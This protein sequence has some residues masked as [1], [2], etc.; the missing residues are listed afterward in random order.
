MRAFAS[1]L[2]FV[3]NSCGEAV[4]SPS[5]INVAWRLCRSFAELCPLPLKIP[6]LL[7]SRRVF[8]SLTSPPKPLRPLFPSAA[9]SPTS[10]SSSA[11]RLSV[12]RFLP[13]A[14]CTIPGR[15]A[16]CQYW[17]SCVSSFSSFG[18]LSRKLQK[19]GMRLNA[20]VHVALFRH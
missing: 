19:D 11:G 1:F 20:Q 16:K 15:S 10:V 8:L 4:P 5:G 2:C 9:P 17:A 18:P 7:P 3:M 13:S 6:C 14:G 12:K